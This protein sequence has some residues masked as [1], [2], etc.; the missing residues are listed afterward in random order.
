MRSC[1]SKPPSETKKTWRLS[2]SDWR[3]AMQ[4]ATVSSCCARRRGTPLTAVVKWADSELGAVASAAS[5]SCW[6][7]MART[8]ALACVRAMGTGWSCRVTSARNTS[9]AL[10]DPNRV[11]LAASRGSGPPGATVHGMTDCPAR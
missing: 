1:R 8:M 7:A 11:P 9:E 4:R 5:R 2:P 6:A 3:A 10:L